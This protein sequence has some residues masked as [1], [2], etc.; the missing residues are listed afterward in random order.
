MHGETLGE[1]NEIHRDGG[2][3]LLF[4]GLA[5]PVRADQHRRRR[6][7]HGHPVAA[8]LWHKRHPLKSARIDPDDAGVG[9]YG[10]LLYPALR[11]V[12]PQKPRPGADQARAKIFDAAAHLLCAGGAGKD[13]L[14]FYL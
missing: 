6:V 8:T 4:V 14:Y 12:M 10:R 13:R 2:G 5:L 1:K 3:G 11:R 7:G 9:A